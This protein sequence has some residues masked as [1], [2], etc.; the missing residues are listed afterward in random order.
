[1]NIVPIEDVK[2]SDLAATIADGGV[3]VLPSVSTYGLVADSTNKKAIEKI[4]TLKGR[5]TSKALLVVC[6]SVPQVEAFFEIP[7][8]ARAII[9]KHWPGALSIK[10]YAK[11]P[12]LLEDNHATVNTNDTSVVVRVTPYPLMRDLAK[13]V[14]KPL[15]ST[16]A[17]TAGHISAY[18]VAAAR[19]YFGNDKTLLSMI[20]DAGDLEPVEPS[21]IIEVN[22][23]K[24]NVLRQGQVKVL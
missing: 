23:G 1:M 11:H 3:L 21:T 15:I 13:A 20:V 17:N 22:D 4:Y 6:A 7:D 9:K 10:L 18:T 2:I 19:S 24:V 16:S 8:G 5:D 14:G 12:D